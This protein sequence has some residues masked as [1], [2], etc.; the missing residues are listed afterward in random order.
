M[1]AL[2]T[3]GVYAGAGNN[4]QY[5]AICTDMAG[6]ALMVSDYFDCTSHAKPQSSYGYPFDEYAANLPAA[7]IVVGMNVL[8]TGGSTSSGDCAGPDG[9]AATQ[10]AANLAGTYD[11][12]YE[13]QFNYLNGLG[14]LG[15]PVY[16][17]L[18]WEFQQSWAPW[19]TGNGISG[20]AQFVQLFQHVATIGH[21]YANI[22]MVWNPVIQIGPPNVDVFPY[23]PGV[24]NSSSN[25]G[26]CDVIGCDAYAGA[27]LNATASENGWNT[28]SNPPE[29][30]EFN[31]IFYQGPRFT[32]ATGVTTQSVNYFAQM[33]AHYGL[34][35]Q[36]CEFGTHS[37]YTGTLPGEGGTGDDALYI[38]LAAAFAYC[39][40]QAGVPTSIVMWNS[41]TSASAYNLFNSSAPNSSAAAETYLTPTADAPTL[42][43]ISYGA[44]PASGSTVLAPVPPPAANDT[45]VMGV[46][47]QGTGG[48]TPS[49]GGYTWTLVGGSLVGPSIQVWVGTAGAAAD[50][51]PAITCTYG[52]TGTYHLV[53]L[54]GLGASPSLTLSQNV[55]GSAV[56]TASTPSASFSEGNV[57]L[58]FLGVY[59]ATFWDATTWSDSQPTTPVA[60]NLGSGGTTRC[61]AADLFI[62]PASGS[63]SATYTW[64]GTPNTGDALALVIAPGGAEPT[65]VASI[66]IGALSLTAAGVA[67]TPSSGGVNRGILVGG[68]RKRLNAGH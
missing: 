30:Y 68:V 66:R 5:K 2:P 1:S 18:M 6:L 37:P 22:Q 29:A 19:G 28:T 43:G 63:A 55:F 10:I 33:A 13:W 24:Y 12:D 58:S 51:Q 61:I 36:I 4:T 40:T 42:E 34:P 53:Q 56:N 59:G 32:A 39:W 8:C 9:N 3:P 57:V 62:A 44:L 38:Q 14:G 50:S 65:G 23:F 54:G 16:V 46:C 7:G 49:G 41:G 27:Y 20:G 21:N 31:A 60:E 15:V 67:S 11:A 52:S 48:F 25:T 26:G 35:L 17:R 64:G 47:I 45:I